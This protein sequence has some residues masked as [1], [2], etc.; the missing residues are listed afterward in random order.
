MAR[1]DLGLKS[2]RASITKRVGSLE[3]Q[4]CFAKLGAYTNYGARQNLKRS[5]RSGRLAR[6]RRRP[7]ARRLTRP[8]ANA[9]SKRPP[10]TVV[11]LTPAPARLLRPMVAAC[12][13]SGTSLLGR[14]P[15]LLLRPRQQC[16]SSPCRSTPA[17]ATAATRAST[18]QPRPMLLP[19][20]S[21]RCTANV[22]NRS[23]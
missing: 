14:A 22:S 5:E 18:C 17:P 23:R 13:R 7:T 1:V 2:S 20:D 9:Q 6:S 3:R 15:I 16:L 10:T 21:S 11:P 12:L 19:Q 8:N 4:S